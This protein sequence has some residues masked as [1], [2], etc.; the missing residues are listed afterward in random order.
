MAIQ[1]FFADLFIETH[2]AYMARVAAAELKIALL[3]EMPN[4]HFALLHK[5]S[6][7]A[8][9]VFRLM[10]LYIKESGHLWLHQTVMLPSTPSSILLPATAPSSI[11][12]PA[13]MPPFL[14]SQ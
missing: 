5:K 6:R 13:S 7:K 4:A 9:T 11:L 8:V 14:V 12:M 2:Y 10:Q 3:P 1:A